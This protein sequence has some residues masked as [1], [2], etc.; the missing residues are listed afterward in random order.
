MSST[1]EPQFGPLS[2]LRSP[3]WLRCWGAPAA[4]SWPA[5]WALGLTLFGAALFVVR[6]TTPLNFSTNEW[7][8]TAYVLDAV[9]NG[10]W[11]SQRDTLGE[12][13]SKP[14]LLT[15]LAALVVLPTG[16]VVPLA[17]YWPSACATILTALALYVAGRA[18]FGARAGFLAAATYLTSLVAFDQMRSSRYDGLLTLPVTLAALCA[19]RAWRTGRGWTW[20]WAA[21]TI[22]TLV[23]GPLAVVLPATGL[24]AAL[25]EPRMARERPMHRGHGLGL[26]I[27]VLVVGGWLLLAFRETGLP[28]FD[29]LFG[30]EMATHAIGGSAA[31]PPPSLGKL[32]EPLMALVL[33]YAP[34]SLLTMV[35]A[36]RVLR[37]A[38]DHEERAFERFVLLWL[39]ADL[40]I[41]T[42]AAHHRDR[43]IY[44]LVPPAAL[45]AGRELARWTRALDE[46]RLALA[47]AVA[48]VALLVFA[49]LHPALGARRGE[50]ATASA[51]RLARTFQE[52]GAGEFPLTY[53]DPG[54]PLQVWLSTRRVVSSPDG[55]TRLLAGPAAAFVVVDGSWT[56][57]RALAGVHIT[58]LYRWPA[59]GR[60]QVRLV[61]NHGQLSWPEQTA[62][63]LDG[64]RVEMDRARL[65]RAARGELTFAVDAGGSVSLVND[66]ATA[67]TVGIRLLRGGAE[68]LMSERRLDPG[69]AWRS[70]GAR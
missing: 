11:W 41:F 42:V 58:D 31:V 65:L 36:W 6:L 34:W 26:A 3:A 55:V 57:G 61:S 20:F 25:W 51:R 18:R 68:D 62:L 69:A 70:D 39:A 12:I 13:A 44:P 56:P 4:I 38:D 8:L 50:Q 40:V 22:G 14:P 7:R 32:Y 27:Y 1:R 23:K 9:D 33:G 54:G 67:L 15:W 53:L 21:A 19:W 37:P 30:R 16:R 60:P 29:K 64:L 2:S 66:S 35:A 47:S 17:L 43:L 46:R 48:G 28:L 59:T 5:G 10:R 49:G 45:L 63:L 24:L 52:L